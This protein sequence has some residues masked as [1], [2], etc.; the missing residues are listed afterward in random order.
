MSTEAVMEPDAIVDRLT[1]WEGKFPLDALRAAVEGK[2]EIVPRLLQV[3]EMTI[4]NAEDHAADEWM[5]HIYTIG[6]LAQFREARAYPLIVKLLSLPGDLPDLL[7]G[8]WILEEMG[9]ILASVARG[10]PSLIK[11]LIENREAYIWSR[12]YAMEAIGAMVAAGDLPRE[13]ALSYFREL[14]GG[15]L[16]SWGG[17]EDSIWLWEVLLSCAIALYPEEIR[18]DLERAYQGFPAG[19]S[20]DHR[21]R[22]SLDDLDAAL[23]AGR[24]TVL[25]DLRGRWPPITD[26]VEEMRGWECFKEKEKGSASHCDFCGK[27]SPAR[28]QEKR[29]PL[30]SGAPKVGRNDPCP[31]GSGRKFKKC[32]GR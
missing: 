2:E 15:K 16:E 29:I 24:D 7:A 8:E 13:D 17:N 10:D 18:Q 1:R 30:S 26:M 5:A 25:G 21:D 32:C 19:D 14:I 23:E 6:L 31:C 9:R 22:M 4:V 27:E 3:L 12:T 11:G 20:G 28:A